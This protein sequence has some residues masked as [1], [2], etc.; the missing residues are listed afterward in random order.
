MEPL[1]S[2]NQLNIQFKSDR[3]IAHVVR[4]V[5]F[6][7]ISGETF[8]LVGE[9]GCGKS[10]TSRALMQLIP[11]PGKITG[12]RILFSQHQTPNASI[13]ITNASEK[14]MQQIRGQQIGM[15]FQEPDTALNPIM[16][17]GDQISEAFFLQNKP[18]FNQRFISFLPDTLKHFLFSSKKAFWDKSIELLKSL[19]IPDPANVVS[20]YPHEL[21][22]GMKQRVLIAIA[23]AGSPSL[24]I[25][26]E[27]TSSL[28]VTVQSQIMRLLGQLKNKKLIQSI[29]FITHDLGLA[30]MF[31]DRL[32]VM[33]AG[34][35]CEIGD[36]PDI[37]LKPFHPYTHA[38]L[39]TIPKKSFDTIMKPIPGQVPD[40]IRPSSGCRFYPRCTRSIDQCKTS[41]PELVPLN[42]TRMVA[43][44]NMRH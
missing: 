32:A 38:L 40:L 23:L 36:V 28:D 1:L 22:G 19:D 8:G 26:D 16:R 39:E 17:V 37:F 31:C 13:N 25:S 3:G 43:C 21:S 14:E 9:S 29:L 10:V 4:D 7:I 2:I 15:I 33:Y 11:Y 18:H 20:R 41:L 27:A 30:S 42:S 6:S 35:M 5:S 24:L 44:W 34:C 12:G